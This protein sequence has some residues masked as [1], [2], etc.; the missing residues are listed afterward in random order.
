MLAKTLYI[1]SGG[2]LKRLID[3]LRVILSFLSFLRKRMSTNPRRGLQHQRAPSKIF[4]RTVR[5]ML[6]HKTKRG[7]EAMSRVKAF[8][9][10]PPPFDKMKRMVVPDALRVNRLA[11]GRKFCRLGRLSSEVRYETLTLLPFAYYADTRYA[12]PFKIILV[13]PDRSSQYKP[14]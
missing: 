10:V 2:G 7:A 12:P 13:C 4:L 1:L 14:K 5:G 11:P 6:P 8:E 3:L 9:G